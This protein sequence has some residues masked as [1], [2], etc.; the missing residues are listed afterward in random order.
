MDWIGG[1]YRNE[2]RGGGGM[3]GALAMLHSMPL[4]DVWKLL[5]VAVYGRKG[6]RW[7]GFSVLYVLRRLA[8]LSPVFFGTGGGHFFVAFAKK[9]CSGSVGG[10]VHLAHLS[11]VTLFVSMW[12]CVTSQNNELL[13]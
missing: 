6:R 12:L 8:R 11:C 7:A 5:M 10:I 3:G 4:Y 13:W 2:A 1:Y 9:A